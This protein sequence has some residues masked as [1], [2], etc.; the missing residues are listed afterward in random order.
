MHGNRFERKVFVSFQSD[1]DSDCDY[2]EL[3]LVSQFAQ[4]SVFEGRLSQYAQLSVLKGRFV[5]LFVIWLL[6]AIFNVVLCVLQFFG[7]CEL[8]I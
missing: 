2:S 8:L 4:F 3:Y 1:L 5:L 6:L 7:R